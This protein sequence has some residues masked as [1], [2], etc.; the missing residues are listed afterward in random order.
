MSSHD[1][2]GMANSKSDGVGQQVE[3][4]GRVVVWVQKQSAVRIPSC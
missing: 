2:G 4:Q 1:Y 3:T